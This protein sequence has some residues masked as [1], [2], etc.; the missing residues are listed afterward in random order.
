MFRCFKNVHAEPKQN[1]KIVLKISKLYFY[2][3]HLVVYKYQL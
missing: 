3:V 1:S 2:Y